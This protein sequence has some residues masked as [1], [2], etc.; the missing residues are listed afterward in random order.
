M[1]PLFP[2]IFLALAG[3][4]AAPQGYVPTPVAKVEPV[5]TDVAS[6]EALMPMRVG[7][8]W[9]YEMRTERLQGGVSAGS[10]TAVAVYRVV[11]AKGNDYTLFLE[12]D[13]NKLDATDWRVTPEGLYQ[14]TS[15]S[16]R[17]PTAPPQPLALLPMKVG[18]KFTWEGKAAM[19]DGKVSRGT[20]E[21]EV[22]AEQTVDTGMGPMSAIPVK[23]RMSFPSGKSESTSWYR[24]DVG[25]VR[26]RQTTTGN[27]GLSVVLT[28]SLTTPPN[29]S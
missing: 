6:G 27:N 2:L 26:Y 4:G 14:I 7:S 18:N 17:I 11:A 8:R 1:K 25:M 3:C 9:T 21:G 15:G 28:L 19:P 16:E 5:N 29:R 10:Q 22:L 12:A 20:A 24:P 13:G 23:I